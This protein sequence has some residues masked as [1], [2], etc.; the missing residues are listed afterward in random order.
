MALA[1]LDSLGAGER[2]L[3]LDR[4][5]LLVRRHATN[6]HEAWRGE[7]LPEGL[8]ELVNDAFEAYRRAPESG[9]EWIAGERG[10]LGVAPPATWLPEVAAPH[11]V[12][13]ALRVGERVSA[14]CPVLFA[15]GTRGGVPPQGAMT[16]LGAW[17]VRMGATG[18]G[19]RVPTM[20]QVY[21]CA[22]GEVIASLD[23][24]LPAGMPLMAEWRGHAGSAQH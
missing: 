7:T 15:R 23:E 16:A 24:T 21:R 4:A 17:A 11:V 9:A 22:G 8:S 10:G 13:F 18:G 5:G 3:G 2:E 6:I 14:G 1:D 19:R 20:R 12:V